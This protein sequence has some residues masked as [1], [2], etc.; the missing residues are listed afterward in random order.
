MLQN[1]VSPLRLQPLDLATKKDKMIVLLAVIAIG[2]TVK[3]VYSLACVL[4][5][6]FTHQPSSVSRAQA[7][8][9]AKGKVIP[10]PKKG[11]EVLTPNVKATLSRLFIGSSYSLSKLPVYQ[12]T[13]SGDQIQIKGMTAP[14]MKGTIYNGHTYQ[15]YIAI[16]VRYEL[17]IQEREAYLAAAGSNVSLT[18]LPPV[19]KSIEK[20]LIF[21]ATKDP[22]IWRQS[23]GK[24]AS[25]LFFKGNMT[26][27]DGGFNPEQSASFEA[28]NRL[29]TTGTS[30]D[31][32]GRVWHLSR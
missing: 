15:T 17:T 18:P 26:G 21:C 2:L 23:K 32:N 29:L 8:E 19:V 13:Q 22:L 4:R 31:L 6:R 10:P 5:K 30:T 25:P 28:V 20:L 3:C 9:T 7:V 11:A 16:K 14:V 12:I 1:L 24:P 27:P